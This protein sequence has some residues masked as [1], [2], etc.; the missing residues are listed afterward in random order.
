MSAGLFIVGT[1]AKDLTTLLSVF[2]DPEMIEKAARK[3]G[4][5]PE[6]AREYLRREIEAKR[7]GF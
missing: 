3:F 2:N 7:S 1:M 4:I 5:D 6:W